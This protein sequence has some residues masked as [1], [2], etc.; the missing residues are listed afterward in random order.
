MELDKNNTSYPSLISEYIKNL[1]KN[2]ILFD[3]QNIVF[4]YLTHQNNRGLLVFHTVGSGKSITSI[5]ISEHFRKLNRDILILSSKSLK[6][7]Y[8]K[9]I[10]TYNKKINKN[11]TEEEIKQIIDGYQFVTS[12]ASNMITQL[13]KKDTALGIDDMLNE[14]N[15]FKLDNKVIIVD[16]AHNLF[17]S[18]VNGSK[19]ANEFYDLVMKSKNIKIIFLTG[20]PIINNFF[21]LVPAL[22]M[23][24]GYTVLP[25]YFTD[26]KKMF[27]NESNNT[28]KNKSKLQSRILGLVSYHGPLFNE[29]YQP[30]IYTIKNKTKDKENFPTKLPVTIE[31]ISMSKIQNMEYIKLRDQEKKESSRFGYGNISGLGINKETSSVSTSYRIKTRQ[32]SNALITKTELTLDNLDIFSP[33]LKKIYKNIQLFPK[34][35][36]IIYSSFLV[37]GLEFF[38]KVLNLYGYSEYKVENKSNK[39]N[40]YKRYAYYTGSINIETKDEILQT[41]NSLE[42]IDG[43]LI[44]LLLISSA[45]SEGLDLKNVRHVHIMEPYWNYARIHQVEARAIRYKSHEALPKKDR[46]VKVYIYLSTF[47]SDYIDEQTHKIK[48]LIEDAKKTKSPLTKSE[49]MIEK[50]TDIHLFE[51][52]IKNKELNDKF[53]QLLAEVSIECQYFNKKINFNCFSCLPTNEKLYHENFQIDMELPSKCQTEEKI[54][55]EEVIVNGKKYYYDIKNPKNIYYF[56]KQSNGYI[57]LENNDIILK[58]NKKLQSN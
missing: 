26:F 12:N 32:I 27:I 58:I 21:E 2:N 42:N 30:F 46:N 19:N 55:T 3:Y 28:I 14:I 11:I 25:E 37:S 34:Q 33:K 16:E 24:A 9:E 57:L 8:I 35:L 13:Q 39:N 7:N 56:N 44:S 48:K 49:I 51:T 53:L 10:E 22:N 31:K 40:D 52:S 45:G 47:H 18:I 1:P 17:N 50:S 29:K 41:F 4:H 15:K 54:S 5:S 20:S 6:S 43:K 38:A 36:G 23:C